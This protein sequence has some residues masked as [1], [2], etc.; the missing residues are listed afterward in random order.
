MTTKNSSQTL[1]TLFTDETGTTTVS[2]EALQALS[3]NPDIGPQIQAGLGISPDDIPASQAVLLTI[4]PDDSS[5]IEAAGNRDLVIEGHNLVL[6]SLRQSRSRDAILA[7]TRYL[8]GHI[9]FPYLLLDSATNMDTTNYSASYATPLFDQ[10][11]LLL[12]TVLA[13]SRELE[14]N[15]IPVRTVTLIITDGGD[16][17]SL[18]QRPSTVR[19]IVE[20]MLREERHIIAAMGI[21]DGQTDFRKIFQSMGIPDRWILTTKNSDRE[22]RK[23]FQLF[24]QSAAIAS[25]SSAAFSQTLGGGFGA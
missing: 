1:Q 5:S 3:L 8:N 7:H 16:T 9:L 23:A 24:S 10:T 13:K 12:G 25:Q 15:G 11:A 17:S 4:M 2:S 18:H 19:A 20:D 21:D 14:A 22:I 6:Q